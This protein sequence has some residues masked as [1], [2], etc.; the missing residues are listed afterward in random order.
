MF[1]DVQAHH[2]HARI[3]VFDLCE[4]RRHGHQVLACG[5]AC[6]SECRQREQQLESQ[7]HQGSMP[8]DSMTRT[9]LRSPRNLSSARAASGAE[10]LVAI[11]AFKVDVGF[12]LLRE[13]AH[14]LDAG[15]RQ[16]GGDCGQADV[17]F[18]S[19]HEVADDIRLRPQ[20][21]GLQFPCNPQALHQGGQVRSAGTAL[22]IG[23]SP[24]I[25]QGAP[26]R[27]DRA[28]VGFGSARAHGYTDA[29]AEKMST[30]TGIDPALLDQQVHHR[31]QHEGDIE[32]LTGINLPGRFRG[33]VG[34]LQQLRERV[35]GCALEVGADCGQHNLWRLQ[36]E[37]FYFRGRHG[38]G[39]QRKSGA[40]QKHDC[41]LDRMRHDC[42]A[43]AQS[44]DPG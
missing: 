33:H 17:G 1:R 39:G 19:S 28:D 26:E 3:F 14:N 8:L 16:Q 6:R 29:N 42:P 20:G 10:A 30:R 11:P 35:T 36:G 25:E 13:R 23:D 40:S 12:D 7:P 18:A 5:H 38:S 2:P 21:P 44:V 24:R 15:R 31:W 37:N 34:P 9:V 41:R 22:Q 43:L 4:L 32:G 27:L